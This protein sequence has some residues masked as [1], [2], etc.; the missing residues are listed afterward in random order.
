MGDRERSEQEER[1][2]GEYIGNKYKVI[3]HLDGSA[4]T[5]DG[6]KHFPVEYWGGMG[7]RERSEQEERIVSN[8]DEIKPLKKFV[9][10][11]HVYIPEDLK[12]SFTIDKLHK[13]SNLAKE[14]GV[15]IYFYPHNALL[16]FR[17]QRTEKA[18]T[19]VSKLLK[20]AEFSPEDLEWMEWKKKSDSSPRRNNT[21]LHSFM[22][23]YRGDYSKTD[24]FP[25]KS[26][27]NW[28][29]YYH[30][31]AYA[32]LMAEAHNYK[33]SHLPIFREIVAAMKKEGVKNFKDLITLVIDRERERLKKE[34]EL[35][36]LKEIR[37]YKRS[38][39][40]LMEYKIKS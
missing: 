26:V 3:I 12:H 17:S 2:G 25:D 10:G 24:E 15:K 22:R 23:I 32:S 18:V 8:K 7:D 21:Y 35:E 11:I 6:F 13:A 39:E 5:A 36:D 4:L 28:L 1:I 9:K 19:D 16:Y 33:P 40:L 14:K 37:D 31:D 20:P 27:L 38:V 30:H 29:R 34:R